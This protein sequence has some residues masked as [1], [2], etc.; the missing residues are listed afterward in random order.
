MTPEAAATSR[1]ARPRYRRADD[2]DDALRLLALGG[3]TPL[4]GG[5]DFYPARVGRVVSESLLDLGDVEAL[6]GIA[7]AADPQGNPVLR[8]GAMTP[9]S[10]IVRTPLDTPFVALQQAAREIGGVQV[11]NRATIGGNLCNASP[12]AD[13]VAALLALDAKLEVASARGR[14]RLAVDEFVLGVRRT[15]LAPDELL[16]AIELPVRS[17][18]ARSAFLKLGHRRSL[19][20]SIAM[21]GLAVEFDAN[22]RLAHCAI[23]VGACAPAAVRLRALESRLLGVARPAL[24]Q[25]FAASIDDG[26]LAPLQPIDDVRATARYRRHAALELARRLITELAAPGA[27]GPHAGQGATR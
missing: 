4:A 5:T 19:V 6:R 23:A 14:R 10:A 1:D 17:T 13:G 9:W 11:Q 12:A 24:G 3:W 26:T 16:V 22:D 7:H 20:I 2:L 27:S 15:A 21:V 25:R 18:D 8:I